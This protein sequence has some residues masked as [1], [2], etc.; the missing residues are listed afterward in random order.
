VV[1][2]PTDAFT[3]W[4]TKEQVPVLELGYLLS[5]LTGGAI[6]FI[7]GQRVVEERY[8][9][10]GSL[11]ETLDLLRHPYSQRLTE[12]A[13]EERMVRAAG[14]DFIIPDVAVTPDITG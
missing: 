10:T 13:I 5:A 11:Q 4:T 2:L 1:V 3:G 7:D 12:F 6:T 8:G 9:G 14:Y